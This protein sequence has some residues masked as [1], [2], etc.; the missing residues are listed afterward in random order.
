MATPE[1]GSLEARPLRTGWSHEARDFTPW[2]AENLDLLSSA[3]GLSL[4]LVAREHAVGRYSLDLLLED[5][6]GRVVIVENQ[7]EPA[8]HGPSW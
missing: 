2:L 6:S 1:F 4:K 7:I 5:D 3:V 8:N